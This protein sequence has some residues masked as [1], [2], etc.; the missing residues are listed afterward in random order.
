MLGK[1]V[2]LAAAG[3]AY[4]LRTPESRAHWAGLLES[5]LDGMGS[6]SNAR[7]TQDRSAL[8]AG[9]G[10]GD[11]AGDA[12]QAPVRRLPV[13]G[14]GSTAQGEVVPPLVDRR[15][16]GTGG[17]AFE[18]P[19]GGHL[20]PDATAVEIARSVSEEQPPP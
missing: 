7:G 12:A 10:A 17:G 2:L 3:A 1:V 16:T 5:C 8:G 11:P 19:P 15:H 4:V 9:T 14:A 13:P 18:D 6:R 20:L